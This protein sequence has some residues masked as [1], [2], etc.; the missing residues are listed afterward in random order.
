MSEGYS[1]HADHGKSLNNRLER[2]RVASSWGV[3]FSSRMPYD[4]ALTGFAVF[5]VLGAIGT[6]SS[7]LVA[8]LRS[9]RPYAWRAWLWG[10]VGFL[11]ANAIL[12]AIIAYSL[13]HVGV[14][15]NSDSRTESLG[16]IIGATV[17]YGPSAASALGVIVGVLTGCYFGKR[18]AAVHAIV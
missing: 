13:M 10:S 8:S 17:V 3:T 2:S 9:L 18:K 12:F 4:L 15:G 6:A 7:F 11:V 16:M 1:C 14:A 5:S